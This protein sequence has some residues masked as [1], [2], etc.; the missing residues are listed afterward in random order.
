MKPTLKRLAVLAALGTMGI[1][2]PVA[3]ASAATP[4]ALAA[5]FPF[6]A[7]QFPVGGLPDAGIGLP[8]YT[9]EPFSFV[10]SRILG[11]VAVI[12]PNVI[13]TAP[14][15][16]VNTNIQVSAAGNVAGGQVAP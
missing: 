2:A 15:M 14:S 11:G 6:L 12:G 16:F 4:P 8:V 7:A 5:G 1:A 9:P 3:N 13:T 10:G